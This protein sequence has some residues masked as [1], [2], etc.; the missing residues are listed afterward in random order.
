MTDSNSKGSKQ[1]QKETPQNIRYGHFQWGPYVM[2]TKL[3]DSIVVRMLEEG[4][5]LQEKHNYNHRLAGQI[6]EQYQFEEHQAMWFYNEITPIIQAYRYGHC[7]YHG[8]EHKEVNIHPTDLWINY[9]KP[10][11]FNPY[12]V[13]GGD[14]SFVFFLDVPKEIG[15]E[16]K[17]FK[18][19]HSGPGSLTLMY[20]QSASPAWNTVEKVLHP[21]TGDF[22]MF[23]ALLYH[24]VSPFQSDVTR[25]SISGNLNIDKTNMDKN[26]F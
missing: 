17:N 5:K 3:K 4:K 11:E 19:T 14:Y 13:H 22:Y 10:G 7:E 6:K 20:G 23:P 16:N 1:F 24:Q 2:I 15:D 25:I 8:L 12:H 21:R 9:M 18:G 26:Y